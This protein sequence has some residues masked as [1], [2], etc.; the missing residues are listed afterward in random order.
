MRSG[1]YDIIDTSVM[2][3][4][5]FNLAHKDNSFT[6]ELS[7][8]DFNNPEHI[9]YMYS[10]NHDNWISLSPGT[11]RIAFNNLNPGTYHFYIKADGYNAYS[12]EKEIVIQI[13]PAWYA[14]AGA[15]IIYYLIGL[16]LIYLLVQQVRHRYEARQRAQEHLHAEEINEAKLQF[17]IN[18]SHEIRTPMSLIISPLEN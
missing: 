4:K 16:G 6:I 17:F 5:M 12:E 3:A 15:K 11:N 13:Y 8:M 9:T 1:R 14:S 7:T 2:D 18:I 10:M